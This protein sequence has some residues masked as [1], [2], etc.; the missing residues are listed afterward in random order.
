MTNLKQ[1]YT[2]RKGVKHPVQHLTV[3]EQEAPDREQL[4]RELTAALTAPG[5]EAAS[6]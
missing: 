3:P 2:D 5:K 4:L 6:P 1:D